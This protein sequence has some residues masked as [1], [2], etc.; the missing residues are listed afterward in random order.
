MAMSYG[1]SLALLVLSVVAIV[2]SASDPDPVADFI[3]SGA[4][5]APVTGANFAFRGLNNVNVTSGQG[6]AA[7][8]AI[9]AT[10]PAL[11]SQGISAAFYNYA[12]CGQVI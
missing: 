9:A 10:F 1:T 2:A 5:G 4:N 3:L 6:S 11:A 8:P 7:K 12:P